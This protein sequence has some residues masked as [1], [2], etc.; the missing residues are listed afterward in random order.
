KL[1]DRIKTL[2]VVED[3]EQKEITVVDRS[4]CRFLADDGLCMIQKKYGV[5]ALSDTCKTF[6]RNIFITERGY[7]ISISYACPTAAMS[8]KEKAPVEFYLDPDGYQ[9]LEINEQLGRI[10]S[11]V[12][13]LKA[14]KGN[15]F[16]VEE[17]LVDIVQFREMDIDTRLILMGIVLDKLKDGDMAGIRQYLQNLDA[18]IISQLKGLPSQPAFMMKLVKEA[19]DKR[20]LQGGISEKKMNK[21]LGIAYGTLKLLNE[22][23]VSDEKVK[24]FLEGYNKYYKP[25]IEGISH[26]FENYFVNFI[27]SKKFYTYKYI[28]AFFLMIFFYVLIRFFSVTV[29]MAEDRAVD[30]DIVVNVINAIERTIVHNTNYYKDVLYLVKEGDYHRLPYVIS[31]MNL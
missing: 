30:E 9:F 6:P 24:R 7:E 28:D 10:G 13:L 31:L 15:Y 11:K 23:S 2:I 20:L 25:N 3:G 26:V 17:M 1:H 18:E 8:L 14:G 16:E 21:L 19:V 4:V 27:F 22:E 5:E 29:C 12:D